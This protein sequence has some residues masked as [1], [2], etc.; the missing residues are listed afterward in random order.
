MAGDAAP[1]LE[2][3][4]TSTAERAPFPGGAGKLT[5]EELVLKAAGNPAV[6]TVVLL[7]SLGPQAAQDNVQKAGLSHKT[8][9]KRVVETGC[10]RKGLFD[11]R[12]DDFLAVLRLFR[13]IEV[14][15]GEVMP[16]D[17]PAANLVHCPFVAVLAGDGKAAGIWGPGICT[18]AQIYGS[19]AA[20]LKPRIALDRILEKE[21]KLM[22][23][24][25]KLD[26]MAGSLE[27][28]KGGARPAAELARLETELAK[29][30]EA[31]KAQEA[32]IDQLLAAAG[33][34]RTPDFRAGPAGRP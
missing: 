5:L 24:L 34:R 27:Q 13:V 1:S 8:V 10:V 25:T 20:A 29:A 9:G 2:S 17:C 22:K 4:L 12:A 19:M 7:G 23:D 30:R 21:R 6:P 28:K 11:F 14:N 3:R 16:Q 26:A 31:A 33:L 18:K 15:V 32:E